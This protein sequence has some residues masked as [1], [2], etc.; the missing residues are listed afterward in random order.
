VSESCR[1]TGQG[2]AREDSTLQKRRQAATG[3]R[4]LQETGHAHRRGPPAPT[5]ETSS[6]WQTTQQPQ[7]SYGVTVTSHEHVYTTT[8]FA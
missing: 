4:P 2:E 8:L 7:V 1:Q 5:S 3:D 6:S